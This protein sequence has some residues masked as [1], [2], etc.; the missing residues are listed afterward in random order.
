[1]D[2]KQKTDLL[3]DCLYNIAAYNISPRNIEDMNRLLDRLGPI[4][5]VVNGKTVVWDTE[6]PTMRIRSVAELVD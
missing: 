4:L 1:M 2:S 5:D 6:A 3:R